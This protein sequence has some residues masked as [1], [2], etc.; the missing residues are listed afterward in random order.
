MR[1][2]NKKKSIEC[3]VKLLYMENRKMNENKENNLKVSRFSIFGKYVV[4]EV[5]HEF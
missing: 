2:G 5:A 3:V 4:A 1:K